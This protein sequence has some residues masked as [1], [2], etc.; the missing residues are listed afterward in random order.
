MRLREGGGPEGR[1]RIGAEAAACALRARKAAFESHAPAS[2]TAGAPAER[3]SGPPS[4]PLTDM[5]KGPQ[6]AEA[7]LSR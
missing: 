5:V 2:T 7:I 4:T 3:G 6:S 1:G